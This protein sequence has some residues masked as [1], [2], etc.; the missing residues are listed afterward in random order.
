VRA[1]SAS[2]IRLPTTVPIWN[3]FFTV[4]PLV[5]V[6]T[7][8]P[9]GIYDIAPKHMAMP[10]GWEDYYCFACTP[11]H[12][13]HANARRTG[14][15]T[16]SYPLP[17]GVVATSLAASGREEGGEKPNLAA[18]ETFPA[19][20]VDG[21]LVADSYLYLECKLDRI[22][23]GFGDASLIVGQVVAAQVDERALRV[24]EGDDAETLRDLPLLAYVSPG[25]FARI[26]HT[27][28][29]PFPARFFR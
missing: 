26:E 6:G 5:L 28:S 9:D 7:K 4:A 19:S 17:D 10:L 29:F 15:F 8:E 22:V 16:V 24:S 23:E 12:G 13:T 14:E 18:L 2:I 3:R 1:S 21:V 11:R 25:R 27:D 20:V